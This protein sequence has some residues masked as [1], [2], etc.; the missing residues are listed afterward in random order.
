MLIFW[1]FSTRIIKQTEEFVLTLLQ[2]LLSSPHLNK[3]L[4]PQVRALL[5]ERREEGREGGREGGN[6]VDRERDR[7]H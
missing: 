2:Q 7:H 5:E 3:N 1:S 4:T 6:E